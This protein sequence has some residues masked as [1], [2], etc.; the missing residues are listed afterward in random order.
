MK[1]LYLIILICSSFVLPARN[2]EALIY[3][4]Q[5][6][7]VATKNPSIFFVLHGYGANEDDLLSLSAEVPNNCITVSIRAPYPITEGSYKWYD[8]SVQGNTK[9]VNEVQLNSST[10]DVLTLIHQLCKKYKVNTKKVII[11]GFSQGAI[12]SYEL[13]TVAPNKFAG[14]VILSGRLLPETK[15]KIKNASAL[16]GTKIMVMHGTT[17]NIIAITEAQEAKTFFASNKIPITYKTYNMAHNI[18]TPQLADLKK[19]LAKTLQ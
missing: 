11:G 3:K 1:Y 12:M 16:A 10:V 14:V 5:A 8:F 4:V 6:A 2:T 19:W 15:A 7:K 18:I 9:T 17:D 13:A